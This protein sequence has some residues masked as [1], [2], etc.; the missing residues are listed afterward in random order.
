MYAFLHLRNLKQ[1]QG[2]TEVTKLVISLNVNNTALPGVFLNS[3]HIIPVSVF[4][5]LDGQSPITAFHGG[6]GYDLV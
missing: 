2:N 4:Y 1:A 6:V 5:S 3:P